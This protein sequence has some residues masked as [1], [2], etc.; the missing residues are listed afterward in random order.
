[1]TTVERI[2]DMDHTAEAVAARD[3]VW[4]EAVEKVSRRDEVPQC[5]VDR[6]LAEVERRTK[7]GA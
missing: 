5:T 7:V 2:V 6:I 4:R 1:M 3:A